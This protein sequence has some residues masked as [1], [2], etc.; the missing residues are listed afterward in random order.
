MVTNPEPRKEPSREARKTTENSFI[1]SSPV[2]HVSA[3]AILAEECVF[4][5]FCLLSLTALGAFD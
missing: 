2:H 3:G 4:I 1:G 5:H